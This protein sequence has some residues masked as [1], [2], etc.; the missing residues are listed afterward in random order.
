MTVLYIALVLIISYMMGS[1]SFS[2]IFTKIFAHVD[3]RNYGSG[4]AGMT[5]VLRN[6]GKLPAILTIVGDFAKGALAALLGQIV[7]EK[8]VGVSPIYGAFLAGLC[9]IIGH[10]YPLFFGFRGGKAVLTS[11]GVMC[12]A[13]SPIVL[14]VLVAIFLAVFFISRMVSVG[15]VVVAAAC[16]VVACVYSLIVGGRPV[17]VD[18]AFAL[19]IGTIVIIKHRTNIK[20]IM[21]GTEGKFE[22]KKK[23]QENK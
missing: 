1:I 21:D 12:V 18:T 7:F 8:L 13:L 6:F 20:R 11:A 10:I 16:P 3:V 9:A 4:N 19:I 17:V 2:I 22:R 23:T 15:S 5:N 14:L